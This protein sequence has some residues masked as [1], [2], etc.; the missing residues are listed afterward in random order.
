MK[1]KQTE[2]EK[3]TNSLEQQPQQ[4]QQ[5]R[6][7]VFSRTKDRFTPLCHLRF[8]IDHFDH[9]YIVSDLSNLVFDETR[10]LP[11]SRTTSTSST[12]T[13]KPRMSRHPFRLRLDI[14]DI[15]SCGDH[16]AIDRKYYRCSS[17]LYFGSRQLS[18][19]PLLLVRFDPRPYRSSSFW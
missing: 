3:C 15:S 10:L 14:F 13:V 16:L 9:Q 19:L 12:S 11:L 2:G 17:T 4:H 1:I 5:P 8:Q 18:L 6:R 7:K